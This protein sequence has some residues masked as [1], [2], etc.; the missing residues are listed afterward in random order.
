MENTIQIG[1]QIWMTQNLNVT[2]FRNG[3]SIKEA[4]TAEDWKTAGENKKPAWCF[5]NND[6]ANGEKYGKLYNWYAVNDPRGLAPFGYNLPGGKDFL[7]LL[8]FLEATDGK[9]HNILKSTL[10]WEDYEHIEESNENGEYFFKSTGKKISGN[11]NNESGFNGLPGGGRS[12]NGDFNYNGHNSFF[13]TFDQLTLPPISNY[14]LDQLKYSDQLELISLSNDYLTYP[15]KKSTIIKEKQEFDTRILVFGLHSYAEYDPVRNIGYYESIFGSGIKQSGYSV[16]CIK[17]DKLS[18]STFLA[19]ATA[20][21]EILKFASDDIKKNKELVI[22]SV[23]QNGNML[24]FAVDDLKHN[25][26]VVSFAVQSKGSALQF[27]SYALKDNKEVVAYAVQNRGNA[28]QYASDNLKNDRE[29]VLMAVQNYG[30]ALK[31]ASDELKNDKL[32]VQ[33]AVQ[34]HGGALQYASD[35]LKNNEEVV[36]IAVNGNLYGS[37]VLQFSSERLRN[38]KGVVLSAIK[39]NGKSLKFVSSSL[40]DD[41]EVVLM[42]VKNDSNSLEFASDNLKDDREIVTLA[43]SN[44]Y[45]NLD[46]ASVSLKNDFDI[47]LCYIRSLINHHFFDNDEENFF[48]NKGIEEIYSYCDINKFKSILLVIC[49]D[50]QGDLPLPFDLN[51]ELSNDRRFI[52]DAVKINGLVLYNAAE[53]LK[54]DFEIVLEAYKNDKNSLEFADDNLKSNKEF[55]DQIALIQ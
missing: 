34:N 28:L 24:E 36:M 10:G 3:D 29:I 52:L 48:T 35:D 11:G 55:L 6:P 53:I 26:E 32:V 23:K 7:Q 2:Q 50:F 31:Y 15:D 40:K 38:E 27:A 9:A 33:N 4:K 20:K 1:A 44:Y 42:A 49:K 12:R 25:K 22:A 14:E 41:R 47:I 51:F 54:S 17:K 5:Y 45:N 21:G 43:V 30:E 19:A 13:W 39:N 46:F 18:N 16:R 8:V 37:S